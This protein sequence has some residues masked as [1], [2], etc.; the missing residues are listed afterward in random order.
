MLAQPGFTFTITMLGNTP[1]QDIMLKMRTF[2]YFL[3]QIDPAARIAW[4][5]EVN[6][7][8]TVVHVHGFL[9]GGQKQRDS[10][11]DAVKRARK[12]AGLRGRSLVKRIPREAAVRYFDYPFRSLGNPDLADRFLELNGTSKRRQLVHCSVGF[13]RDGSNG[14]KMT[15]R[16]AES[17]SYRRSLMD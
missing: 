10:Y 9:H 16:E 17:L 2:A 6:R 3:R 13:W 1:Y 12:R 11:D 5:A 4:A 15:R 8:G 14:R 7:R